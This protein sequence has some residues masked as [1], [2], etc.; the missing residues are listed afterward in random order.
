VNDS[1]IITKRIELSAVK[2]NHTETDIGQLV[3]LAEKFNCGVVQTLPTNTLL[4]R[5]LIP[6]D[7]NIL[8]GSNIGFPSGAHST[9]IKVAETKEMVNIGCD[10][11]DVVI[12]LPK[13]LSH[14]YNFVLDDLKAVVDHAAG[15]PV[16]VIIESDYLTIDQ[17]KKACELLIEA[18]AAYVKTS[19]GW[20]GA[21][22]TLKIITLIKQHVGNA[23]KIKA[24]GGIRN[25]TTI[26]QMMDLGVERFGIGMTSSLPIFEEILAYKFDEVYDRK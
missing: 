19:T 8:V 16:K 9:A 10:E 5:T 23:V 7:H 1:R 24:S 13:F 3:K 17:I 21:G 6:N 26:L 2:P 18:G 12:N 25:L 14:H 20:V 4:A 15:L 11:I 22:A